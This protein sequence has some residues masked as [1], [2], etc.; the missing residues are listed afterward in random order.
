MR[1]YRDG[2]TWFRPPNLA[3]FWPG[4]TFQDFSFIKIHGCVFDFYPWY[5]CKSAHFG[6]F[7]GASSISTLDITPFW[8]FWPTQDFLRDSDPQIWLNFDL[9]PLFKTFHLW[10]FMGAS[11]ISTLDIAANLL[12]SAILEVR[13]LV[14][15]RYRRTHV[16]ILSLKFPYWFW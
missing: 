2:T 13:L 5:R 7:R 3:E 9:G 12:I 10:K 1:L 8:H 16:E 14:P 6:H 15:S 11:S 4:T